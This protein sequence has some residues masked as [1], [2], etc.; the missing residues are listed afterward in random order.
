MA[1]ER[2]TNDRKPNANK[3]FASGG[4]TCKLEAFFVSTHFSYRLKIFAPKPDRMQCL[5]PFIIF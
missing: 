2:L 5:N 3:G 1:T 4:Q